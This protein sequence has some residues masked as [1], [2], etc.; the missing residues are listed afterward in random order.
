MQKQ[1]LSPFDKL[2]VTT[3]ITTLILITILIWRGDRVGLQIAEVTP[4]GQST[5]VSTQATIRLTFPQTIINPQTAQL[6][7]SPPISAT[8]HWQGRTLIATPHQPLAQNTHY[9][10]T[11]SGDLQNNQERQLLKPYT[12]SFQTGQ[13]RV[14]YLS[15]DEN[16]HGQLYLTTPFSNTPAQQL[17]HEPIGV[18]DYTLSP[19]GQHIVYTSQQQDGTLNL[20]TITRHG[21]NERTLVS[22]PTA[23]CSAATWSPTSQRLI[24][25][26]RN[27]PEPGAAPGT[28]R[29]W[30]VD[31]VSGRTIPVFED[32]QW[33]GLSAQFSPDGTKLSYI[34]PQTQEVHI[35]NL[36]TGQTL[37]IP[38]QTGEMAS[39]HPNSQHILVT[40]IQFQGEQFAIHIY[41]VDAQTGQLLN[42]SN[43][44]AVNDGSP[45]FDPAGQWIIFG[46]KLTRAPMGKQLWLMRPDGTETTQLTTNPEIHYGLPNWSH[47]SQTILIQQYE[48]NQPGARP[49]IWLL[50]LTDQTLHQIAPTGLQPTWLP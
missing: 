24:Y 44:L 20:K 50:D 39:W 14:L 48:I 21:T 31:F 13:P 27:I 9:T 32:T 36:E 6:T 1:T 40:E 37:I 5:H 47:D 45:V 29:L 28:P 49:A 23:A 18:S 33:L 12:W 42:L 11:L 19:D 43:T 15:W 17:T 4:A 16:D 35:Y 30:W 8:V 3:I 22:C 2:V 7:I 38:S 26:R 25:E 41:T 10:L 34:A 46:R